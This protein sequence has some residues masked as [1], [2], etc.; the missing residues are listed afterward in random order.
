VSKRAINGTVLHVRVPADLASDLAEIAHSEN[1]LVSSVVR[2]LVSAGI[3][4]E[5]ER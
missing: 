5:R 2:R 1:N 4:R 3:A